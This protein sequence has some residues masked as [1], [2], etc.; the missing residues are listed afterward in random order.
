MPLAEFLG[1]EESFKVVQLKAAWVRFAKE[2]QFFPLF[3][4]SFTPRDWMKS[5]DNLGKDRSERMFQPL[6]LRTEG[7]FLLALGS[8][9]T[10]NGPSFQDQTLEALRL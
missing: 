6:P 7:R 8:F 4:E 1:V 3:S 5:C 2:S 9:I 10:S